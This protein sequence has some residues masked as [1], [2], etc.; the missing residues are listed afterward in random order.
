MDKSNRK[1][2]KPKTGLSTEKKSIFLLSNFFLIIWY[3]RLDASNFKGIVFNWNATTLKYI[4]YFLNRPTPLKIHFNLQSK[5]HH[6][7]T[8]WFIRNAETLAQY[9]VG[10]FIKNSIEHLFCFAYIHTGHWQNICNW[11]FNGGLY[12]I[13]P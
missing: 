11:S 3:R 7:Y 5:L 13:L 4:H 1:Q 2:T 12:L 9:I 8:V 6:T 10:Q